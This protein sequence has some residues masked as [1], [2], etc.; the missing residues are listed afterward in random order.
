MPDEKADKPV[1]WKSGLDQLDFLPGEP[2]VDKE[3]GW[4]KLHDRLQHSRRKKKAGGYWVA[5]ACLLGVMILT[6]LLLMQ[7]GDSLVKKDPPSTRKTSPTPRPV[8]DN[9][10]T[11]AFLPPSSNKRSSLPDIKNKLHPVAKAATTSGLM[12]PPDTIMEIPSPTAI[13]QPVDT[14]QLITAA[15]KKKLRVVHI[16]EVDRPAEDTQLASNVP[17]SSAKLSREDDAAGFSLSRNASD[18][19]VKIK[20]SSSN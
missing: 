15:P 19:I 12:V 11:V 18:N 2:P 17:V 9:P 6:R 10:E 3:A 20:L 7:P 13:V 14:V 1:Y 8:I 16:N 5:A 4:Q